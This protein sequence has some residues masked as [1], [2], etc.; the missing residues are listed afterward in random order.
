[1]HEL[2]YIILKQIRFIV[3]LVRIIK[4][5][6]IYTQRKWRNQ[7]RSNKVHVSHHSNL[8]YVNKA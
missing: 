4:L 2:L 1:M 6:C 3:Y 7:F 5:L 8:K